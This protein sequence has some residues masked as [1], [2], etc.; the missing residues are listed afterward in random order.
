MTR[1]DWDLGGGAVVVLLGEDEGAGERSAVFW[2]EG[3]AVVLGVCATEV[4]FAARAGGAPMLEVRGEAWGVSFARRGGHRA[5]AL[6]PGAVG[7]DLEVLEPLDDLERVAA[8]AMSDGELERWGAME[9]SSRLVAFYEAWTC[10]E[11]ALKALGTGLTVDP[12]RVEIEPGD[13]EN[14]TVRVGSTV[15]RGRVAHVGPLV[16]AGASVDPG[17]PG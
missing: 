7:V 13:A 15:V 1:F 17:G 11:A 6:G 4:S 2:R 3:I 8:R 5:C 14:R 9:A 16:V 12:R 10:K